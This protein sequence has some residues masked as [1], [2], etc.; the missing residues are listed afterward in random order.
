[1]QGVVL[2]EY[3]DQLYQFAMILTGDQLEAE[4]LVQETYAQAIGALEDLRDYK[5]IK[6]WLYTIMRN[7]WITHRR[8]QHNRSRLV[9]K[10]GSHTSSNDLENPYALFKNKEDIKRLR[11]TIR[12]L[13]AYLQEVILLHEFD[14]F[15]YQETANLLNCPIGT[16]MSRLARARHKIRALLMSR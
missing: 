9:S 13:P 12:R 5:S 2:I 11:E 15:S 14:D 3:L 4:D 7:T 10:M 1:M 8:N 16:V 6:G